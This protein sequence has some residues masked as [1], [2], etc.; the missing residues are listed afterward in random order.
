MSNLTTEIENLK[1]L[2]KDLENKSTETGL[3]AYDLYIQEIRKKRE[4]NPNPEPYMETHHI[5]PKFDNGSNSP[6]NLIRV[7]NDEHITAHG[8]RWLVLGKTGDRTAYYFRKGYH[9]E[10]RRLRVQEARA[11]DKT[12]GKGRFNSEY[13]REMG[14]RSAMKNRQQVKTKEQIEATQA[15]GLKYGRQTG[16][17]NQSE[18]TKKLLTFVSLWAYKNETANGTDETYV[19]VSPKESIIEVFNALD[20]FFPDILPVKD[21]K[22]NPT[23]YKLFHGKRK[24]MFGWRIVDKLIRSEFEKGYLNFVEN[25]PNSRILLEEELFS[26]LQAE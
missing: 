14:K 13:Q 15:L 6:E 12:E 1:K 2:V 10:A 21:T 25:N 9:E 23:L 3:N 24:Q 19:F 17:S 26:D 7:T 20:K 5:I 8:I 4:I 22:Q 16:I 11:R 18:T